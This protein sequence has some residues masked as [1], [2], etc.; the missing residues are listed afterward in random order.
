MKYK[1]NRPLVKQMES[2][3]KRL[4]K[5]WKS[6]TTSSATE[7]D[8]YHHVDQCRAM[9]ERIQE[10][11][12]SWHE[13]LQK[14]SESIEDDMR[15][16]TCLDAPEEFGAGTARMRGLWCIYQDLRD[17]ITMEKTPLEEKMELFEKMKL[18][19]ADLNLFFTSSPL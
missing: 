10:K 17:R 4:K 15:C 6:L 3:I 13:R 9:S 5:E 18:I 12:S 19:S 14:Y 16:G 2:E 8:L 7:G 11:Y 1:R